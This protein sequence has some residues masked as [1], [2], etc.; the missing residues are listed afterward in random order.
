MPRSLVGI[1][2]AIASHLATKGANIV[3]NCKT[4]SSVTKAV[5]LA[6][7]LASTHSVN[8]IASQADISTASGALKLVDEAKSAF[9][10]NDQFQI[11]TVVNNA[12]AAALGPLAAV[13]VED[14]NRVFA[15][16]VHGP[17]F[18]MQAALPYLPWDRSGRIVNIS[19]I[20]ATVPFP[21]MTIL[22]ASKA[23]LDSMTRTWSRELAER[24]TVNSINPLVLILF[25][26]AEAELSLID[27]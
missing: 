11:D 13:K 12:G 21:A 5:D 3:L 9:T 15:V 23:A 14:W 7:S 1:G 20:V 10:S 24:A 8:A 6:A 22:G 19:S 25:I 27:I 18:V 2:A 16:S 4:D 17:I 26:L